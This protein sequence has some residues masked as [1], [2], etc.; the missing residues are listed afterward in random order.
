MELIFLEVL[1]GF[2]TMARSVKRMENRD[3]IE[4]RARDRQPT[5]AL[6]PCSLHSQMSTIEMLVSP[7]NTELHLHDMC[8]A[9][10]VF[11]FGSTALLQI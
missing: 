1:M 4:L 11:D 7:T 9:P 3:S 8:G 6:G 2:G 5:L 10:I